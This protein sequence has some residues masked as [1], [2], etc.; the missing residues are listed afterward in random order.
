M[1]LKE[2]VD[3]CLGCINKNCKSGCPLS[4]DITQSIKYVKEGNMELQNNVS[5]NVLEQ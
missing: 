3:Y 1:I 4:N 2:K 5:Q